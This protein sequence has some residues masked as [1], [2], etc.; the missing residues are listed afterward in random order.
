MR[1]TGQSSKVLEMR[2]IP[3][4]EVTIIIA[5]KEVYMC[6]SGFVVKSF[7][8]S[9]LNLSQLSCLPHEPLCYHE[10]KDAYRSRFSLD[11]FCESINL[12]YHSHGLEVS[13]G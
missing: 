8:G 5:K 12:W 9:A 11:N 4:L 13:I 3:I 6:F 10:K 2:S 1:K 7:R